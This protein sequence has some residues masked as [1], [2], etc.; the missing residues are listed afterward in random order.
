MYNDNKKITKKEEELY[1]L[2]CLFISQKF[3]E[4][5]LKDL[6]DYQI[7]LKNNIYDVEA[8]DIIENG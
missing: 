4:K 7:Y 3:Y 2:N 8:N 5:D 1:I 6:P